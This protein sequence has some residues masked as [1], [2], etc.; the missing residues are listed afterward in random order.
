MIFDFYIT[1]LLP[2][3]THIAILVCIYVILGI[4]LNLAV[5]QTGLL[6]MGHVAFYGIGA[7]TSALLTLKGV[8]FA[9]AFLMAGIVSCLFGYLL[10][11]PIARLKGDYLALATLGFNFVVYAVM[12]NWMGLTRGP[13][14][15]PGIPRPSF[16]GLTLSDNTHY[17]IFA[18]VLAAL[19]YLIVERLTNSPF[20]RALAATRDDEIGARMLGK[21]TRKLK[22][23][24]M[25]ISAFFAGLAGSLYAHYINFIDP[26]TFS[27]SEIILIFTIV[28]VG[29]LASNRGVIV[30]VLII[31]LIQ[32]SLR[33][34]GLPS[35]ILGPAR[36][37]I[38]SL[39]LLLIII[40]RPKGI[41]G[42][43]DLE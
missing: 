5:G 13:L 26:S 12:L 18:F 38:Y 37:M 34:F 17:L 10:S 43:V 9:E 4:S 3:L 6:N 40:V 42:K 32:E 1:L 36:Q 39:V 2:Y 11:K 19:V 25:L 31:F 21:D 8:S 30:G 22:T 28:I 15:L 7:Y 20:G 23:T 29:G 27:I 24:A 35:S 33:F 16:L 41:L 14:G